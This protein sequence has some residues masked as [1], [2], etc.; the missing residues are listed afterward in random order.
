MESAKIRNRAIAILKDEMSETT[1][2]H[3]R[4]I[5]FLEDWIVDAMI[6]FHKSEVGNRRLNKLLG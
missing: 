6:N 2:I 3:I 1:L 4:K 5:D